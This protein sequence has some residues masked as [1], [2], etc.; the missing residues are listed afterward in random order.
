MPTARLTRVIRFDAAHR[1]YRPGWSPERNA[2]VFGACANE[3]GHGHSYQ[4]FVTVSGPVSDDTGMLV[5]LGKLDRILEEEVRRPFD[6]RHLNH[7]V[8]AFAFGKTIPTVE[9]LSVYVWERVSLR[10]P[11]TVK[12][13]SVRIQ[14]APDLYAEY[15][16]EA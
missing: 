16:G 9:A 13:H 14:E 11:G 8:P 12:L 6:H 1:Y 15:Q 2:E 5:D 7:D 10:L 3:H 4:C